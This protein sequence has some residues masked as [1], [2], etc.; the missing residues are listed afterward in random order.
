M[1]HRPQIQFYL[2]FHFNVAKQTEEEAEGKADIEKLI[3]A[4]RNFA[5]ATEC[6]A[7]FQD[8]QNKTSLLTV[9]KKGHTL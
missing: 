4:I 8:C 5:I 3:V 6:C 7:Y 9:L 2:N 1:Q